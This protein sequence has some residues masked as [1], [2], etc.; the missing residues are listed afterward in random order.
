MHGTLAEDVLIYM[1]DQVATLNDVAFDINYRDKTGGSAMHYAAM[2]GHDHVLDLL[3]RNRAS[4]KYGVVKDSKCHRTVMSKHKHFLGYSPLGLAV[5]S[6]DNIYVAE[7]GNHRIRKVTSDGTVTTLAGSGQAAFQDGQGTAAHFNAPYGV[8]VDSEDNLYVADFGNHCIRKV[9]SDG[10]VTIFA[11]SRQGSFQDAQGTA[12]H[13]HSPID[14]V[15]DAGDNVYVCDYKNHCVRRITAEG[16]VST[17]AGSTSRNSGFT[18]A[19]G[20]N[21]LFKKPYGITIDNDGNLLIA[22]YGNYRIRAIDAGVDPQRRD[23]VPQLPS[24]MIADFSA[25][26][27]D[28]TFCDVEFT[29]GTEITTAHRS[30]LSSRCEYFH[31]MF[32]SNFNESIANENGRHKCPIQDTTM[33]AFKIVLRYLYTDCLDVPSEHAVGVM[34]LADRYGIERLHNHVIRLCSRQINNSNVV[35]WFIQANEHALDDLRDRTKRYLARN[36]R[37]IRDSNRQSLVPLAQ[38]PELMMEVMLEAI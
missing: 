22:D 21:A 36:F 30:V 31:T 33:P 26:L 11:G 7:I 8:A 4:V 6:E 15:V 17:I 27:D 25:L 5:D 28:E 16:T 29:V 14:L 23:M 9:T 38:Y 24:T 2:Y 3:I 12:A 20:N 34:R 10:T 35:L 13:F 19:Q 1:V 37:S 32:T 18:D